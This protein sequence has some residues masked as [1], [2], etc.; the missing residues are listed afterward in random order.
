[1]RHEVEHRTTR[2][3]I[4]GLG[5]SGRSVYL[6]SF[7]D[8]TQQYGEEIPRAMQCWACS[9]DRCEVVIEHN[10]EMPDDV[11]VSCAAC[12]REWND[13]VR[14]NIEIRRRGHPEQFR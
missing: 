6:M 14:E 9:Y 2:N 5:Q 3:F 4:R 10:P 13:Q 11:T 7:D 1:M 12:N 8:A